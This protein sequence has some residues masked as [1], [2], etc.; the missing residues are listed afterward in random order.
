[1]PSA[2]EPR[3]GTSRTPSGLAVP[4]PLGMRPHPNFLF[5]CPVS[6]HGPAQSGVVPEMCRGSDLTCLARS[7]FKLLQIHGDGWRRAARAAKALARSGR[8]GRPGHQL[9][10]LSGG[11]RE[12]AKIVQYL[13]RS[14]VAVTIQ[15]GDMSI[16][17][18]VPLGQRC[19]LVTCTVHDARPRWELRLSVPTGRPGT[20]HPLG[21]GSS[22][23]H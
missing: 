20:T 3:L 11:G 14:Q 2:C 6:G 7:E 22:Q 13:E 18:E 5:C 1:M 4:S 21:T 12:L 16:F 10:A 9:R 8:P 23:C 19:S 15:E 17:Q